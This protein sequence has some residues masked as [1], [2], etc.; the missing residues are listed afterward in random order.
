MRKPVVLITGAN[1]EIGHGLIKSIAATNDSS[2][3]ALD[4]DPLDD[5][6]KPM[7]IDAVTA[8]I[9]DRN[10][11]ERINGKYE[12]SEIYH[13][14]SVLST[15]AEFSP[16]TAHDVNVGGTLNLLTIAVEQA[17]S[18]GAAVKF[19]FPSSIAV[20]GLGGTEEKERVGAINEEQF[21]IPQTMYGCNKLYCEHLGRYYSNYF[22]RLSAASESGKVDFRSIRFP[23]IIS[24]DTIPSGGTSDFGPEMIHAAARNRPYR[25][26][27]RPDTTM[28]FMT[29]LDAVDAIRKLMAA[30][31][32]HL[33]KSVYHLS[34]FSVSAQDFAD[35]VTSLYNTVSVVFDVNDKRQTIVDSWPKYIDDSAARRDWGWSPRYDF[36]SAFEDYLVPGINQRYSK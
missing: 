30:K 17:S 32:E 14:A 35:K 34:S 21:C 9:L 20:Y 33:T 4:L 28:P 29:M 31:A 36:D 5:D 23:G 8:N 10:S 25:C 11:L 24:A 15:R 3:V 1:G 18:Q 12:I 13:L 6:L 2:V 27:V 22:R 16:H 7:V 19:F 26:F